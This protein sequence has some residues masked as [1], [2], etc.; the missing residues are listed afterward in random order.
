M[1]SVKVRN[2]ETGELGMWDGFSF[3]PDRTIS[4]AQ[5]KEESGRDWGAWLEKYIA[6]GT[7]ESRKKAFQEHVEESSRGAE[8]FEKKIAPLI[9]IAEG[10]TPSGVRKNVKMLQ[11]L[12]GGTDIS[13]AYKKVEY[14]KIDLADIFREQFGI[15]AGDAKARPKKYAKYIDA[16]GAPFDPAARKHIIPE[17]AETAVGFATDPYALAAAWGIGKG[18]EKVFSALSP[19]VQYK[20]TRQRSFMDLVKKGKRKLTGTQLTVNANRAGMKASRIMREHPEE[21]LNLKRAFSSNAF[22]DK[23]T[24]GEF[25]SFE[26]G[27]KSGLKTTP[28]A[29][30]MGDMPLRAAGAEVGRGRSGLSIPRLPVPIK[31]PPL[32]E[33]WK[34]TSSDQ[35]GSYDIGGAWK[36]VIENKPGTIDIPLQYIKA[37]EEFRQMDTEWAKK[38]ADVDMPGLVVVGKSV[39]GKPTINLVDG[40][41]RAYRAF[42][43]GK[44]FKAYVV[45]KEVATLDKAIRDARLKQP[46]PIPV[47]ESSLIED[48]PPTLTRGEQVTWMSK[49]TNA[50]A[51]GT[52][53]HVN[54]KGNYLVKTEEGLRT[55][56][57]ERAIIPTPQEDVARMERAQIQVR[58][59]GAA[60]GGVGEG[61]IATIAVGPNGYIVM[62]TP[63]T[64]AEAI[65]TMREG[66][67][68]W[69]A[70]KSI[71]VEK[72]IRARIDELGQLR[73]MPDE[74][75]VQEEIDSIIS[76]G[77]GRE[78]ITA[79]ETPP[80]KGPPPVAGGT[81]GL[82]PP[83]EPNVVVREELS[84][85]SGWRKHWTNL[86]K[87][88]DVEAPFKAIKAPETGLAIKRMHSEGLTHLE[89][90]KKEI[91]SQSRM[92]KN[93]SVSDFTELTW[94]AAQPHLLSNVEEIRR[95]KL[96]PILKSIRKYLDDY[97]DILIKEGVFKTGWPEAQKKDLKRT[98][99]SNKEALKRDGITP[100]EE[101][102]LWDEIN[103][104]KGMLSFLNKQDIKYVP[105]TSVWL[106]ELFKENPRLAA[107]TINRFFKERKT[108]DIRELGE[109]L[110][111]E[112]IITKDDLDIRNIL[113]AYAQGVGK[114]IALSKV[115]SAAD[116]EG[117]I[118]SGQ[119]ESNWPFFPSTLAPEL[120][121][122]RVHPAFWEWLDEY[123]KTMGSTKTLRRAFAYAKVLQFT[124]FWMLGAYDFMQGIWLGSMTKI[125]TPTYMYKAL[126]SMLL[127]DEFLMRARSSGSFS[128]PIT[129]PFDDFMGE[130][131]VAKHT[132]NF[133]KMALE[134][135]KQNF[136]PVKKTLPRY[137]ARGLVTG[138]L[139]VVMKP[140]WHA[141]WW[142]DQFVRMIGF[143]HLVDTGFSDS[144]AGDIVAAMHADYAAIPAKT[145][146]NLAMI[147]FTA[148]FAIQMA[149]VQ[150]EMLVAPLKL[151]S[152]AGREGD[153]GKRN[154]LMARG[155]LR[156]LMMVTFIDVAMRS[157]GYAR[158]KWGTKY[159]K[160]VPDPQTGRTRE[161][162]INIP[163]P[164]NVIWRRVHG[165]T[166]LPAIGSQWNAFTNRAMWQLHPM[167][168]VG[169]M[170]LTNQRSDFSPITNWAF[171]DNQKNFK[172]MTM[173]G[174]RELVEIVDN[175]MS[176]PEAGKRQ[177]A[178]TAFKQDLGPLWSKVIDPFST[179]YLRGVKEERMNYQMRALKEAFRAF[180][181]ERGREGGILDDVNMH[182]FEDRLW[183]A[184]EEGTGIKRPVK[185]GRR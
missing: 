78:P 125:K 32:K 74:P 123:S 94:L 116:K 102:A 63:N 119:E 83:K 21:A 49:A 156:L 146:R 48:A 17:I 11:L 12:G 151:F 26:A 181:K 41:H 33:V 38:H 57:P 79:S 178:I 150:A 36:Y 65:N 137:I 109:F 67:A 87:I 52:I 173:F 5:P 14:D 166:D 16:L 75:L 170:M 107:H 8:K 45:P 114:K 70:A 89:R 82:P 129:P 95:G 126:K 182:N 104:A 112:G 169:I 29:V 93:L 159:V 165:L 53:V 97:Q 91:R 106:S 140:L 145:R 2:K 177:D 143:H 81:P 44:P 164:H 54:P 60:K 40:W 46:I 136:T 62:K 155:L 180:G 117:L 10:L 130:I 19:A 183:D 152:K 71:Q 142:G 72:F 115:L 111:Q 22:K 56:K 131:R 35:H 31:T 167:Y 138:P 110:L 43:E 160:E 27:M 161:L 18:F 13:E 132:G 50:E 101:E 86:Y 148:P 42:Q 105:I 1:P 47:E 127:K 108:I 23:L 69:E 25:K 141:A 99:S 185:E 98:I 61:E 59:I 113:A 20:L 76:G 7:P 124:K 162:V 64:H 168:R 158:D 9:P 39:S 58:R 80:P 15:K 184:I 84:E 147:F 66:G 128:Q 122:K 135:L 154:K 68:N 55:I 174:F 120:K 85:L 163:G 88:I 153:K 34:E 6:P 133:P 100:N 3:T 4:T 121:G 90:V 157:L 118:K 175:I 73:A 134:W 77:K 51:S 103:S 179:K 149:K 172:D 24:K 139:D 30:G 28:T 92:G 37:H 96:A 144:E 171:E 176:I